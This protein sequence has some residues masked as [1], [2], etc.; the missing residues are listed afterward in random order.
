MNICLPALVLREHISVNIV[1]QLRLIVSLAKAFPR[2]F[3][4]Y[5]T[6]LCVGRKTGLPYLIVSVLPVKNNRRFIV[7]YNSESRS[8]KKVR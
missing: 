3:F 5:R 4:S 6:V 7:A 8:Y 1:K 2:I